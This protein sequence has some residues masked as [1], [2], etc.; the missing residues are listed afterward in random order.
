VPAHKKDDDDDD[1]APFRSDACIVSVMAAKRRSIVI[2]I[3]VLV[4][5]MALL[6]YG[7]NQI[8]L[9]PPAGKNNVPSE[10]NMRTPTGNALELDSR[11]M[12]SRG[13]QSSK[14]EF[15]FKELQRAIDIDDNDTRCRRYDYVF[16]ATTPKKRRLFY[17][18]LVADEPWEL[19]SIV[20]AETYGMFA[21]MVFVEGN[22]T[23]NLSPRKFQRLHSTR[24]MQTLFGTEQLQ[25]RPFVDENTALRGLAREHAQRA[26][27]LRGWKELGMTPDDVGILVDADETFT[28]DFLHAVQVCDGID[29]LEY[30]HHHCI[31][32]R[33]K[34]ISRARVFQGSPECISEGQ[35]WF[36]PDMIVGA[37]VEGIGN[38]IMNPKAPRKPGHF[39]RA[40]GFGSKCDDWEKETAISDNRYPLWNAADFRRTCGGSMVSLNTTAFPRHSAYTAFHF[41]NFFTGADSIRFKY[42]TYGHPNAQAYTKRLE[43]MNNALKMMT[44]CVMNLAD[45][46]SQKWKR[47]A[48]GYNVSL[49][50]LPIYFQDADYRQRRHHFMREIV[51]GDDK[52]LAAKR[53]AT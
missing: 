36:H 22:R 19:F 51:T 30:Q 18:A 53:K 38:E 26:E 49:P 20:A 29:Q 23:Q 34:I 21:A 31:H 39:L 9:A 40:T 3:Y 7:S 24:T 48:G 44:R 28:R 43:D 42:R 12:A 37:C 45:E 47:V 46:P 14:P 15:Y 25:I 35:S 10:T 2:G 4:S 16:N 17:G 1:R 33:V 8:A 11:D 27:I 50:Q 13:I 41:H 5:T 6:L 32:T 52:S